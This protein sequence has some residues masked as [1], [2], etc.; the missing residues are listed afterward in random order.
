MLAERGERLDESVSYLKRA[1]EAEPDNGSFLDSLGWAYFKL[2]NIDKARQYLEKA[3]IYSKRN[4]TI[5]EHLGD[6][7]RE[8]G[9][10]AE[11]RK[12]WEK[13]LEYSVEAN[14]IARLRGKLKDAR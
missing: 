13:A 6:V 14:E 7:L 5:H 3:S 12:H 4:S 11:A 10:L 8:A 2:G 9:R 1:L